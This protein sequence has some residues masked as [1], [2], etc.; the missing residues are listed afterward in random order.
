MVRKKTFKESVR[1]LSGGIIILLALVL[2]ASAVPAALAQAP[3]TLDWPYYGNDPGNMRYVDTDLINPS[4]V[5]QLQPAWILHIGVGNE[6]TSF[7][8]QPIIVNGTLY[9]S[10]PHDH[11]YAVDAATGNLK[12][13]YN[14]DLPTLEE[15]AICCGQTNRG[16]AV[17]Q[18]KVFIGQLDANL[19]ALD[20]N[21]G[22][23]VWKVA[24]DDWH[25]KWTETMA[26]QYF[27]GKVFI[28]ASGGEFMARGHIS[29]YDAATGKMLWRF[30]TVPGPGEFG[31]DTWAGDSWQ[32]GGATV[33]TTPSVDPDLGLLYLTT[34]NAAPDLDGA[35]RA[36]N[37]LFS[38]SIVAL[39]LNTGQYRWHFQE[40]HHDIWDYDA[41]QPTHLFTVE[42]DGQQIPAIGHANKNGHYFILDRRDGK[43]LFDV[44]EVPVP[45]EPAWQNPS[46]TQPKPATDP[47]IPQSVA[48]ALPGQKAV[49]L[50]T[51]PQPEPLVMQ[52]GAESGPEWAP[53]AYSPRTRFTYIPAGGYEPWLFH[54]IPET[55][56]TLGSL[57][58]DKP[59]YAEN[60]HYGLFDAMDTTT[61][62]LAWQ[63]KVP[64]RA[65]SGIVV[66][67]DL[68]FLGESNGKFHAL[69]AKSGQILWT[70]QSNDKGVG[71]ANGAPAVYVVNGQEYIVS[72][73]G[74]NTQVRSGQDSPP[75]DAL[76]AFALPQPGQTGP[77]V[78]MANPKQVPTGDIP[79]SALQAKLSS[80]PPDARVVD[81]TMNELFFYP[82]Q[83]SAAPG[84]KIAVHLK[85]NEPAGHEHT[86]AFGLPTGV[87]ALKDPIPPGE[88]G[89][90]AFTAPTAPGDYQFWCTVGEHKE[91]GMTG[92]MTL[93][94]NVAQAGET[95]TAPGAQT[96]GEAAQTT[97][98]NAAP[99]TTQQTAQV[100]QAPGTLPTT[101]GVIWPRSNILLLGLGA[102]LLFV[103]LSLALPRRTD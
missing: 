76:I 89:Y 39:D 27:D 64:Q 40:V 37:N 24:V 101:G 94:G 47:L 84:E 8:S 62:K 82:N 77:N 72:G 42:K 50:W 14:P 61:G 65:T 58:N 60:D 75:G 102:L 52:P 96:S 51:P 19:V 35:K 85:N 53:A 25:N 92:T 11:V 34:G 80:P 29:A 16:V 13:T 38:A 69:D 55:P 28:G 49:P 5:A 21:T 43:P 45:T 100:Q 10:S 46:P 12:W 54:A 79:D 59:S 4:N 9:V 81:I 88:E 103:G 23:V 41:P 26:P 20:A 74:G 98:A 32:T 56:N 36:G 78:V 7:E 95:T 71:G 63:M 97:T 1:A 3:T 83:F 44:Q 57:I 33:W 22:N 30:N 86:I 99:Q 73:F 31:N 66:A 17:G 87:I 6:N 18:D 2:L 15:M 68:V 48:Q 90:F 93:G 70:Y 67:G 91:L